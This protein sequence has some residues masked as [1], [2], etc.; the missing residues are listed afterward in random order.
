MEA[1]MLTGQDT[2]TVLAS[3]STMDQYPDKNIQA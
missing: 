3:V 1:G 2:P